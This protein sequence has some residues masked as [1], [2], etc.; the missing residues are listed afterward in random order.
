MAENPLIA[1]DESGNTGANLVDFQQ[2]IFTLASVNYSKSEANSIINS[3]FSGNHVSDPKFADDIKGNKSRENNL[4][5]FLSSSQANHEKIKVS[6]YHKK[7]LAI[8]KIIDILLEKCAH[9]DDIDIYKYGYNIALSNLCY[10]CFPAFYGESAFKQL[11][12]NFVAMIRYQTV[13]SIE[14]FYSI[15]ETMLNLG[16]NQEV[17]Y[18]QGLLSI[19]LKSYDYIEEILLGNDHLSLDP[20][21]PSFYLHCVRWG[22]ELNRPFNLIHD[23]S[24]PI[25]ATQDILEMMMEPDTQTTLIGYDTRSYMFPLKAR[26]IKFENSKVDPRIQ[27]ADI[28]AGCISFWASNYIE[29]INKKSNKSKNTL[30]K[31]KR[32]F[33]KLD[34][35]NLFELIIELHWPQ[36]NFTPESLDAQTGEGTNAIEYVTEF[37]ENRTTEN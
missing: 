22:E 23:D 13:S 28:M 4:V 7:Y 30:K 37:L 35:L 16:D 6:I 15:V 9:Q 33:K 14:A 17:E 11:L 29:G 34:N 21:I 25:S 19:I 1:F 26:K 24:K 2:P 36:Q 20:A 8:G 32:F 5:R 3:I 10:F 31:E 12:H 27:L 18:F